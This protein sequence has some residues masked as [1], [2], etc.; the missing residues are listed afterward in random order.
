[1]KNLDR[2]INRMYPTWRKYASGL[3]GSQV[4]GDDCLN[5]TLLKLLENQRAKAEELAKAGTL[6]FYVNRA[7][8]LM[9]TDSTSRY[10]VKYSKFGKR[11]DDHS[12]R[13]LGEP[14]PVWMGSRI[15]NE[16]LDAYISL[17]P[18]LDAT[19]LRLYMLDDFSYKE[20][21]KKTGIPI[22]ELYRLVESAINKIK[23]NVHRT[24]RHS[25]S[26]PNDLPGL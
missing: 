12:E 5:E 10:H 21:S 11:W 15:D 14:V 2:E 17:M 20:A 3:L 23:R 19:I 8:F 1:V 7:L 22:K 24:P 6:E 26:A 18:E 9:A 16:Y 25:N 4:R 13:H